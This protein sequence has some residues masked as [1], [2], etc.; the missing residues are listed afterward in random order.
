VGE[1]RFKAA[2]FETAVL[3]FRGFLHL[4]NCG[5]GLARRE[6]AMLREHAG[7]YR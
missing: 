4:S 2:V 5:S 3:G 1:G 7:I 6:V